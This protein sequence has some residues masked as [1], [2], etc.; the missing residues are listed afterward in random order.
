MRTEQPGAAPMTALAVSAT[1]ASARTPSR[2]ACLSGSLISARP[3]SCCKLLTR[4][5]LTVA[6]WIGG[7]PA[8]KVCEF[9]GYMM[10]RRPGRTTGAS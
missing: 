4:C 5:P 9:W 1:A 6:T 2:Y 8:G 7:P 3:S 10:R